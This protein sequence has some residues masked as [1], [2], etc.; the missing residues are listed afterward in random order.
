MQSDESS[1]IIAINTISMLLGISSFT[2]G[3]S[4]GVNGSTSYINEQELI[5]QT[6]KFGLRCLQLGDNL[7][8]HAMSK[9]QL[10]SLKQSVQENNIRL[11]V[12]ARKLTDEHL[13]QYMDIAADF[14]SPLLRFVVDGENYEP[15]IETIISVIKNALPEL[16]EKKITLGIENHDRFKSDELVKMMDAVSDEHVGICF[17]TVNSIGAGEGLTWVTTML[18]PY[19]VNLH[20]KDFNIRRFPHNMGFTVAGAIAGQ[21]MINFE[22]VMDKLSRYNRC[23]SAILEQWVIPESEHSQTV[24]KEQRW[25]N[26]SIQFLKQLPYFK[27]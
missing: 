17:D 3:W 11:E 5:K 22:M 8:M 27:Q 1:G 19:T 26:Q 7:P 15:E 16:K 25:A 14:N 4:I 9:D 24:E 23:Q 10:A 18:A 20:I 12:G 21:G 13:H 6:V 2:Y